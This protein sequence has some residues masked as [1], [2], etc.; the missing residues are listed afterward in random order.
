MPDE[1]ERTEP[2]A[3]SDAPAPDATPDDIVG[4]PD[5]TVDDAGEKV[6]HEFDADG[7]F[8]GWHKEPA[9]G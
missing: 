7:T 3:T 4:V 6:V 5:G 8:V 2:P 9:N 1:E